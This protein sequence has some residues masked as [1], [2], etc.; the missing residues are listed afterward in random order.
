MAHSFTLMAS[1]S[2]QQDPTLSPEAG[3]PL[4]SSWGEG[5]AGLTVPVL[6]VPGYSGTGWG[7]GVLERDWEGHVDWGPAILPSLAGVGSPPTLF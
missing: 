4:G 2:C 5:G 1:S 6:R 7:G 3:W